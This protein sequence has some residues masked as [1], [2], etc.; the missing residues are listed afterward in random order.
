MKRALRRRTD[1]AALR[2]GLLSQRAATSA[3][4][5]AGYPHLAI[6]GGL[7]YAN[8][9]PL[10]IPPTAEFSP[11]WRVGAVLTWSP[12]DLL[13]STSKADVQAAKTE[14][15][16]A[17]IQQLEMTIRIEVRQALEQLRAAKKGR[18]AALQSLRAN[19]AAHASRLSALRAGAATS[20]DVFTAATQLDQ[21]RLALLDASVAQRLADTRLRHVVVD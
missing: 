11:S 20:T 13:T 10:V 15:T 7:T 6:F 21:A 16:V 19:E 17:R 9:N 3:I 5:A 8:P 18:A 2:A 4:E 12:N 1:L 14:A